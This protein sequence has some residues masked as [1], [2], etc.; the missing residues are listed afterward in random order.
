MRENSF[1]L[2]LVILL[3]AL[4]FLLTTC[5]SLSYR[6]H[7]AYNTAITNLVGNDTS[8]VTVSEVRPGKELLVVKRATNATTNIER[9]AIY[10]KTNNRLYYI[11]EAP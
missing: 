5:I 10:D 1:S 8:S 4:M 11:E 3:T 6:D 7:L 2:G 9:L